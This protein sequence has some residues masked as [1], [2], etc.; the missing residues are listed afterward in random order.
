MDK[1]LEHFYA[2]V[3]PAYSGQLIRLTRFLLVNAIYEDI[4]RYIRLNNKNTFSKYTNF[5]KLGLL[6]LYD[7][8]KIKEKLN[9][10]G[11]KESQFPFN[12][13]LI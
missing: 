13:S 8:A 7:L 10:Y 9:L 11:L 3:S 6:N 4:L 2:G 1:Y 12:K 5:S